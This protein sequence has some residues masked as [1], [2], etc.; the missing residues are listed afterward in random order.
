MRARLFAKTIY[1]FPPLC[2][3]FIRIKFARCNVKNFYLTSAITYTS[4]KPHIGNTYEAVLCDAIARHKRMQ[5][6]N[7]IFQTGTDEHG[8]KVE[9]K[10][11]DKGLSPK[12][13]VDGV[14]GEIRRI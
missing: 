13:F 12:E 1:F 14:A 9:Q 2:Y 11:A 7:V 3:I 5:G 8:L 4:G 10:A 6:F